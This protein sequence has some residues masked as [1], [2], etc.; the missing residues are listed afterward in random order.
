FVLPQPQRQQEAGDGGDIEHHRGD[1]ERGAARR[2]RGPL[3][4]GGLRG[5]GFGTWIAHGIPLHR[6]LA[7]RL[8][9]H[10]EPD[11]ATQPLPVVFLLLA[12]ACPVFAWTCGGG[13]YIWRGVRRAGLGPPVVYQAARNGGPRPGRRVARC[14]ERLTAPRAAAGRSGRTRFPRFPSVRRG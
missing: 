2:L 4:R 5:V 8:L 12:R 6:A 13:G 9:Q 11:V 3:A 1:D 10:H 14:P 7:A